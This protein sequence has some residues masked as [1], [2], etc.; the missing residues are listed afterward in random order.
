[1][2]EEKNVKKGE[3][4]SMPSVNVEIAPSIIQWIMGQKQYENIGS[5][6]LE[7]LSR[8]KSG[9]EQP[10]FSQIEKVSKVLN[11]PLGYFFLQT[12][13]QEDLSLLKYR[14]VDSLSNHDP[15]RNLI[16]TINEMKNIQE[17]M[18]EY[19]IKNTNNELKFVGLLKDCFDC[20]KIVKSI[21]NELG[22]D[23]DWFKQM[24]DERMAF[25][26]LRNK[27]ESCGVIV[28]MS[29]IVRQN[30]R[31]KLDIDEVRAFALSDPYAPLI[32]INT[33]DSRGAKLFSLLHELTHLWLGSDDF[34]NGSAGEDSGVS[35]IE[36]LCNAVAAELL[37]PNVLF[38]EGWM[39]LS[40]DLDALIKIESLSSF[41]KCG[42]T[43]I[44]RRAF[45]HGFISKDTYQMAANIALQ[46]YQEQK[47]KLKDN[48]G[49]NYYATLASR[50]D[51]RFVRALNSSLNEGTVT[52]SEVYRL[53]NTNRK[54]FSEL[55][56]KKR[57]IN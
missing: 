35:K 37:V 50:M 11:I 49:G 47:D 28:M 10:T 8:W 56:E 14:T 26:T 42:I 24:T 51:G 54:T 9:A 17:W 27:L 46:R 12:P 15:S 48:K 40:K 21:R 19:A 45:D 4:D 43:V 53:T 32:F 34:Y 36:T 38:K 2:E 5:D 3:G 57:G 44:A 55:V 6:W 18:R 16:D 29:G 41:F 39:N 22:I 25:H 31:R 52:P 20:N 23:L 1:M 33:N 30:N 7:K 13:P